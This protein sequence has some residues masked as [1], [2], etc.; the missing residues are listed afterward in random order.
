MRIPC[1]RPPRVAIVRLA[2]VPQARSMNSSCQMVILKTGFETGSKVGTYQVI[3][4]NRDRAEVQG[5]WI[6]F[7]G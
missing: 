7:M 4:C 2:I 1:L 3:D 5:L 6:D